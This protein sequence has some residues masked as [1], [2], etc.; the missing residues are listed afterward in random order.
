MRPRTPLSFRTRRISSIIAPPMPG[1]RLRWRR[2]LPLLLSAPSHCGLRDSRHQPSTRYV[3]ASNPRI[4]KGLTDSAGG[5]PRDG[6][7]KQNFD[8]PSEWQHGPPGVG[9]TVHRQ[10][11]EADAGKAEGRRAKDSQ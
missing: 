5:R 3:T 6:L 8:I 9:E 10:D 7:I 4:A 11:R 2:A 1:T